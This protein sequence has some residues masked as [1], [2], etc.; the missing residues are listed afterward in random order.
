[1]EIRKV[2]EITI[3]FSEN[4]FTEFFNHVNNIRQTL[5][6][7]ANKLYEDE[8]SESISTIE[9]LVKNPGIKHSENYLFETMNKISAK[10]SN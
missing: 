1:M 4:E 2:S 10:L 6:A 8:A 9:E 3:T 5:D 7:V